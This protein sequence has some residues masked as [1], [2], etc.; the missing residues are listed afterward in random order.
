[1]HRLNPWRTG[2]A[3]AVT[4]AVL[5]GVCTLAVAICPT[6]TLALL[7]VLTHGLDL[8]PLLPAEGL[9]VSWGGFIRGLAGLAFASFAAGALFVWSYNRFGGRRSE[10]DRVPPA[11][12]QG[13]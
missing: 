7:S 5:Y 4:A 13:T 3:L 10:A 9:R 11:R 1:M 2:G 12:S 6:G 8:K